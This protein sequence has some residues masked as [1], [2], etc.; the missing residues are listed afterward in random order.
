MK[1]M[2][3]VFLSLFA[4]TFGLC[5]NAMAEPLAKGKTIDTVQTVPAA[6]ATYII[7]SSDIN[8][9]EIA[10]SDCGFGR[11]SPSSTLEKT[12]SASLLGAIL[13]ILEPIPTIKL[14]FDR[15]LKIN[16]EGNF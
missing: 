12:K 13:A 14:R 7:N 4:L 8:I 1:N 3:V 5:G 11:S 6:I 2:I 15:G 9:A 10:V 16:I